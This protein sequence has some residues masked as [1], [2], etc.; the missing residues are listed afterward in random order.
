MDVRS[1]GIIVITHVT[2]TLVLLSTIERTRPVTVAP[3]ERMVADRPLNWAIR[4]RLASFWS[5]VSY[6]NIGSPARSRTVGA[7]RYPTVKIPSRRSTAHAVI[8]S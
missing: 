7:Q 3:A 6:V 8:K 2:L 4:K 5:V 1:S